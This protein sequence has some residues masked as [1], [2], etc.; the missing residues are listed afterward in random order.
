[1]G[2]LNTLA[3]RALRISDKESFEKE[4]SHLLDVFVE[5]GYSRFLG[6]RAFLK[7]S[8][9]SLSHREP[10]ER[11]PGVLPYV[12]GT[13]DK[14]G[15]ILRS[16]NVPMTFRPLNTICSSL[17]SVKDPIDP[18]DMKGVYIIPCSCG[19]PYIGETGRSINQRISEHEADLK[20]RQTKSS[21]LAEHAEKTN[22]H[23]CIEEAS[24][25]AKVS[26]FHHRKFREAFEIEKRPSN[27]NRDGGWKIS[28]CWVPTL[29]SKSS[30]FF[31][32]VYLILIYLFIPIY[33]F[34]IIIII[35][36][37][38]LFII[39]IIIIILV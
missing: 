1:M 32:L 36:I 2:V 23:V 19:P 11:V 5:N 34:I 3:M 17:I 27:L 13:T 22:H 31:S 7:A 26:H 8:K 9:N 37:F 21:A 20:H 30:F 12:Q 25:I 38:Y 10:K 29:S 28:Q 24:V 35:L 33:F 14:I 18:K 39:I 15:R 16:H 6:P 4:K